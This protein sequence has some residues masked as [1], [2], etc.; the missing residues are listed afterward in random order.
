MELKSITIKQ[1]K[2]IITNVPD[3]HHV[4]VD[5]YYYETSH[6][7]DISNIYVDSENK[8]VLIEVSGLHYQHN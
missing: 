2:E 5:L 7:Y 1:L 6:V 4:L 3:D 8:V